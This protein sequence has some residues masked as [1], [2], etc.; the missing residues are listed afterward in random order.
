VS[1]EDLVHELEA[2]RRAIAHARNILVAREPLVLGEAETLNQP[3]V[4]TPD[5]GGAHAD[6]DA[7]GLAGATVGAVTV[8]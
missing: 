7:G 2:A 5:R 4:S 3:G 6:A 8:V 1:K